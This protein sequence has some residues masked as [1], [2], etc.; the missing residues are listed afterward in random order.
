[1]FRYV[2]CDPPKKQRT[3][4]P[5]PPT[6]SRGANNAR[7]LIDWGSQRSAA[8]GREG[9]REERPPPDAASLSHR[10]EASEAPP[11]GITFEEP[12]PDFRS[13]QTP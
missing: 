11:L 4:P 8:M 10:V 2:S 1:M 13:G 12:Q 9:V 6:D 5:T 3:T 7:S